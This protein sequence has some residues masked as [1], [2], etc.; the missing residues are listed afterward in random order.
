MLSDGRIVGRAE[1]FAKVFPSSRAVK[2]AIGLMAWA[3]LEDIALDGR[4]D[5]S[6]PA[7]R[8]DD[9]AP[10]RGEPRAEQGHG[11][12]VPEGREHGFVL[13]EESREVASGRYEPCRYVL[14]PS[15]GIERFTV[16]LQNHG[17]VSGKIRGRSRVRNLRTRWSSPRATSRDTVAAVPPKR[18]AP[19]SCAVGSN[20]SVSRA[21]LPARCGNEPGLPTACLPLG[22]VS[23]EAVASED[24]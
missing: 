21:T 13:Q 18:T 1:P 16:T 12:Q 19:A 5:R 15:S 23:D 9:G 6:G 14:G 20:A 3:V 8:R 4:I 10:H 2:R 22:Q 24:G 17:R 11:Q 7:C